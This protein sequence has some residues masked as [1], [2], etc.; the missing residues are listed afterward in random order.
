MAEAMGKRAGLKLRRRK[1]KSAKLR[2]RT[3][4]MRNK[5]K[6]LDAI[7]AFHQSLTPL[8]KQHIAFTKA[9]KGKWVLG[10]KV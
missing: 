9:C 2:Q 3:R 1:D 6:I 7:I 8:N 10:L 4:T 5:H